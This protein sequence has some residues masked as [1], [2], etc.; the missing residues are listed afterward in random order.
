MMPLSK[1]AAERLHKVTLTGVLILGAIPIAL[2]FLWLVL[3]SLKTADTV[4]SENPEWLP[5]QQRYEVG[6]TTVD[7][8]AQPVTI[9]D[10]GTPGG[11][12]VWRIK[13]AEER[14]Q[15]YFFWPADGIE[16]L[17]TTGHLA[18]IGTV[19]RAVSAPEPTDDPGR[20]R[21]GQFGT[22]QIVPITPAELHERVETHD[23]VRL[24]GREVP[25]EVL[26]NSD[27]GHIRLR[28]A[29]PGAEFLIARDL[30]RNDDDA[31]LPV[32]AWAADG[33]APPLLP[34]AVLAEVPAA[35]VARV[36][37]VPGAILTAL[38]ERVATQRQTLVHYYR[39][40]G[41]E[42]EPV[43]PARRDADGQITA[44]ARMS[45]LREWLL[46]AEDV[47]TAT[48][49]EHRITWLGQPLT[50]RVLEEVEAPPGQVAVRTLPPHDT[51]AIAADRV[52]SERRIEPQWANYLNVFRVEPL[53][54]YVLNTL[55]ITSLSILGNV[56]SCG[57][58]GY[59]FARLQFRGRDTLFLV[60]LSTMMLPST[61]TF[62]PTYILYVKIG[63]L[64]TY[65]PLIVPTFLATS[66]FFVFL[67]R[68]F[69]MTI[70][71]DL[72]DAARIDGCDPLR[73]FWHIMLPMARPAVIT[74]T[75]FTFMAAWNDFMGPLLY[76]NTDEY[77]TLAYGLYSFKTSFGYKFPHYMMAASTMMMI[78]TLIIF[79]LAQNAFM[80]GVVVTGV[81]G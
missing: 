40:Q 12:G 16:V 31:R 69:F 10:R 15:A 73:T 78:P 49:T 55:F 65:Y 63:W 24:F 62:L 9:V 75:V 4:L 23:I 51:V 19:L 57:L 7:G 66:A 42:R 56:L 26:S 22:Q 70:P 25:V 20:V 64:D 52:R 53:H 71:L 29:P 47:T 67:Y 3:S 68:Q 54:K 35:G 30:L 32:Q 41:D 80:R 27:S 59:A 48:E 58:V 76:L 81:K 21:V 36:R 39:V 14:D 38:A 8:A 37:L 77:Q 5:I 44:V 13:P 61:I 34:V 60:L 72:E 28:I 33:A 50:V 6:A 11:L 2:P 74:V 17:T 43:S 18:R 46:P 1:P 79:F 45:A